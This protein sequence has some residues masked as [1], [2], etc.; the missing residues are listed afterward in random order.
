VSRNES[1]TWQWRRS[2]GMQ[3]FV[4]VSRERED[5]AGAPRSTEAFIKLQFD[6]SELRAMW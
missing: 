2:A 5:G 6:V 1:L 4:G 3:L